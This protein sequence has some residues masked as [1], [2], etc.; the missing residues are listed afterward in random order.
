M[1]MGTRPLDAEHLLIDVDLPHY[2]AEIALKH[3]ILAADHRYAFQSLPSATDAGWETLELLLPAMARR[4]PEQFTLTIDGTHWIWENH[5][6]GHTRRFTLGDPH[7]LP[8]APLDWVGREVQ[9]DLLLLDAGLPGVP[10]TAG[11]LCFPNAWCL[12]DKIGHSFLE[13]HAPVPLFAEQIGR[14]SQLLMERLKPGRPVWRLNWA[15]RAGDQL[16]ASP[17]YAAELA[18]RKQVITRQNAGEGCFLRVERQTLVRLTR[19]NHVLFIIHTYHAAIA[20]VAADVQQGRM[21]LE[22]LRSTPPEMLD[23]KG[24]APFAEP[25]IAYLEQVLV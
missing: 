23:Y 24:I 3:A 19:S 1:Q 8:Y 17:R 25:L 21:L 15:I 2:A 4:N 6:L 5:V 20:S 13:I 12:D 11:Q 18:R 22:V 14:A 10:L 7:T 9:E 16:D